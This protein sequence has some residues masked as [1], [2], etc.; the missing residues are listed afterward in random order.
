[1]KTKTRKRKVPLRKNILLVAIVGIFLLIN[2]SVIFHFLNQPTMVFPK[3]ADYDITGDWVITISITQPTKITEKVNAHIIQETGGKFTG[4]A[5]VPDLGT[6]TLSGQV[7]G[8]HIA[9]GP[10]TESG[11][12]SGISYEA[13]YSMEGTINDTSTV[14]NGTIQGRVRTLLTLDINGTMVAQRQGL[15]PTQTP[16]K[17][18]TPT[19]TNTP[20]QTPTKTPT[21]TQIPTRTP[22]PIR[23]PTATP[24]G[25]STP[26]STPT[27]IS[28]ASISHTTTPVPTSK[29]QNPVIPTRLVSNP[30]VKPTTPPIAKS[31][32][33]TEAFSSPIVGLLLV[34]SLAVLVIF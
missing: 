5:S 8:N 15:L 28:I 4:T 26:T 30:T 13:T 16:T 23:T 34:L 25:I 7:T 10:V 33:I 6:R 22:T 1:M 2:I 21:P 17:T 27:P 3:A 14:M 12:M 32:I 24:T 9:V 31:G 11:K 18:P 29:V 20:T 19:V